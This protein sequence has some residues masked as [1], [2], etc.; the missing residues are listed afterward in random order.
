MEMKQILAIIITCVAVCVLIAVMRLIRGTDE[1]PE[2]GSSLPTMSAITLPT[3]TESYWDELRRQQEAVN[4]T[5]TAIITTMTTTVEGQTADVE[6]DASG[7][8]VTTLR[9]ES[10]ESGQQTDATV[11]PAGEVP[12]STAPTTPLVIYAT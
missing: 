7:N 12:V 4:T 5:S 6:T 3:T 10:V 2:E 9:P 1:Q 8:P 11:P